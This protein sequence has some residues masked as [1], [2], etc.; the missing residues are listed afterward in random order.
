M[1]NQAKENPYFEY[2]EQV[3]V[4]LA[5]LAITCFLY[6]SYLNFNNQA[7]ENTSNQD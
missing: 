4:P 6:L 2:K 1:N 3:I 5:W 7:N